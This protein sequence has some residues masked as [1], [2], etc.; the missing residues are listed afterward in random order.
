M[1]VFGGNYEIELWIKFVVNFIGVAK[2]LQ[3]PPVFSK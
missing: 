2:N 3:V 1:T